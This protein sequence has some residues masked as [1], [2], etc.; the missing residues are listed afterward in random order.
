MV[1]AGG[2]DQKRLGQRIHR[3]VQNQLAQLFSQ[4]CAAGFAGL[5]NLVYAKFSVE[6]ADQ[7]INMRRFASAVY[8]FEADEKSLIA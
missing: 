5:D 3:V 1:T 4:G 7:G 8:A 6:C 2:K